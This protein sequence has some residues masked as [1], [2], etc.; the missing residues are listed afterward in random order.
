[1][2]PFRSIFGASPILVLLSWPAYA[3]DSALVFKQSVGSGGGYSTNSQYGFRSTIGQ[4]VI[5]T[6][7]AGSNRFYSGFWSGY[8]P[9]CCE[10]ITGD[11]NNDGKDNGLLDLTFIVDRIF[12]AGPPPACPGEGDLDGNGSPMQ[13]TDLTAIVDRIF[14]GGPLPKPCSP[15]LVSF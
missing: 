13:V 11:V 2:K 3:Q 7:T 5:G 12:R 15:L 8:V 4:G 6:S 10:G 1:M 9:S 14:R